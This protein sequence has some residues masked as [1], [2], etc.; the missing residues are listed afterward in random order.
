MWEKVKSAE[1]EFGT[2][3]IKRKRRKPGSPALT[4]MGK[5]LLKQRKHAL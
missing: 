5:L 3:E 1:A 2:T 4:A